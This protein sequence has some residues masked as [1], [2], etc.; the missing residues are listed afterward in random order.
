MTTLI[1]FDRTS[2]DDPSGRALFAYGDIQTSPLVGSIQQAQQIEFFIQ[3]VI[4]RV[5]HETRQAAGQYIKGAAANLL[6][7]DA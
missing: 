4:E 3:R 6:E 5:R 1:K 7:R 2:P